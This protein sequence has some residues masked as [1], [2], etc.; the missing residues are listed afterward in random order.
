MSALMFRMMLKT[1]SCG[2]PPAMMEML[3]RNTWRI[4]SDTASFLEFSSCLDEVGSSVSG[5]RL[6]LLLLLVDDGR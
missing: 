1:M 6:L 5:L 4:Q 3:N 2:R